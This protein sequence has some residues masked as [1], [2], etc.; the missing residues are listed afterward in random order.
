MLVFLDAIIDISSTL[1]FDT[2]IL[3]FDSL[4]MMDADAVNKLRGLTGCIADVPGK[5]LHQCIKALPKNPHLLGTA[6]DSSDN[7]KEG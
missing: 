1:R 5:V 4:T 7:Y 2:N 3:K 6:I